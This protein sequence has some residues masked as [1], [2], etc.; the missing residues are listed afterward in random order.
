MFSPQTSAPLH[1][2]L[3]FGSLLLAALNIRDHFGQ[4]PQGVLRLA[5]HSQSGIQILAQ[6]NKTSPSFS[7]SSPS[8]G[9]HM[10]RPIPLY[11]F[12][13]RRP[14]HHLGSAVG[15]EAG[16]LSLHPSLYIPS[17]PKRQYNTRSPMDRISPSD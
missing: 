11:G 16:V 10:T 9:T 12:D 7:I 8:G 2:L 13:H 15:Q 3:T 6:L 5:A 1:V 4:S 14:S 17:P